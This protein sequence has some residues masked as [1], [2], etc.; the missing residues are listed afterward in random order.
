M[1][2]V[3]DRYRWGDTKAVQTCSSLVQSG[4]TSEDL[5]GGWWHRH[6]YLEYANVTQHKRAK[7][8]FDI[9]QSSSKLHIEIG[10][11]VILSFHTIL[12]MMS[13]FVFQLYNTT[14]INI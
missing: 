14:L 4:R 2:L 10:P 7:E 6:C 13:L 11:Y 9:S 8:R 12:S 3:E 5:A 1:K